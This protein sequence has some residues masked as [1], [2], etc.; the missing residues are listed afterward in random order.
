MKRRL[1]F[2]IMAKT[3]FADVLIASRFKELDV[4][5]ARLQIAGLV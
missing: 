1:A 5:A 4:P 3:S 2:E